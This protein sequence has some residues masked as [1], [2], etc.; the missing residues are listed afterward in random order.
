MDEKKYTINDEPVSAR[1]L[2]QEARDL[3]DTF[4]NDGFLSTSEAAAICRRHGL[5]VGTIKREEERDE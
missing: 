4:G 2:I 5:S 1:E 3:D